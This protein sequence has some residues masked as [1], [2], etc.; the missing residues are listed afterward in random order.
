MVSREAP[1]QR[2]RRLAR[3]PPTKGRRPMRRFAFILAVLGVAATLT[4]GPALAASKGTDRPVRG[5]STS[6]T[7]VDLA[8]GTGTTTGSGELSHL[9][10]FTFTNDITSLTL[11]GGSLALTYTQVIVAANG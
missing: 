4:A 1:H 5:T 2:G 9:G 3:R 7:T 10:R 6:T 8:N 11:S